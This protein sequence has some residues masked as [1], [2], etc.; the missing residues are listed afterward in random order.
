[1]V[2]KKITASLIALCIITGHQANAA[3]LDAAADDAPHI[4]YLR[5]TVGRN[6]EAFNDHINKHVPEKEALVLNLL[7]H[8]FQDDISA[9]T[10]H[11]ANRSINAT[12]LLKRVNVALKEEGA[13]GSPVISGMQAQFEDSAHPEAQKQRDEI[14]NGLEDIAKGYQ[15]QFA[16]ALK[17]IDLAARQPRQTPYDTIALLKSMIKIVEKQPGDVSFERINQNA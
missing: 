4:L 5:Q 11:S 3:A 16:T 6:L 12:G 10:R 9:F 13:V 8:S 1:M 15:D 2:S 14:A 17:H 7:A